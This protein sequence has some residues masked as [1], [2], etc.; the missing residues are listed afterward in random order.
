MLKYILL[1]LLGLTI[2]TSCS[3]DELE[4]PIKHKVIRDQDQTSDS[5][6]KEH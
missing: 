4:E 2:S 5:A 1:M 3:P 6:V